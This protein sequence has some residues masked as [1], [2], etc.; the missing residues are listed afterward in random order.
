MKKETVC[1][2]K[3][4][5]AIGPYSQ[6]IKANGF[7]FCSGINPADGSIPT[8]IEGQTRRVMENIKGLLADN[9]LDMSQIVKTTLFI[10][11]MNDFA[12]INA[13]YAEYFTADPPARACVEVARLPK[14][15]L[16]EIESIVAL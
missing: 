3:A 16:I 6:A 14:D 7:M 9:G 10:K 11:D 8:D 13:V 5:A 15:L 12:K 2:N 4:P 1:S